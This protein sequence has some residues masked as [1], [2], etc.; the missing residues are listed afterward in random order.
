MGTMAQI[1]AVEKGKKSRAEST[2]TEAHHKLQKS[3]LIN[4]QTRTYTP[5]HEN[6]EEKP[7]E[8]QLV[9]VHVKDEIKKARAALVELF[10]VTAT[11]DWGN[12]VAHADIVVDGK[13]LLSAV[14]VTYLLFLEKQLVNLATF[15]DKLPVHDPSVEW[16]ESPSTGT[17]VTPPE[18]TVSTKKV[19]RNHQ[20]AEATK[21]HPAQV[22]VYTEDEPIGEWTRVRHTSALPSTQKDHLRA[23]IEALQDAVKIAREAANHTE[24]KDQHVGEVVLS[25]LFD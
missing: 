22:Q 18:K 8:V 14:P 20:L 7:A 9:Q 16:R 10:D 24:V 3:V 11:K 13:V 17:W 15:I 1:I 2:L 21:E 5:R 4:G 25:Y 6:G 19:Y 23:K 12:T